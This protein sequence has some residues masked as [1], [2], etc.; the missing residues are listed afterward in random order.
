MQTIYLTKAAVNGSRKSRAIREDRHFRAHEERPGD[1]HVRR[2][3]FDDT[4]FI[5]IAPAIVECGYPQEV[6]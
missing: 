3:R 4:K 1:P 5:Y 2:T 6:A